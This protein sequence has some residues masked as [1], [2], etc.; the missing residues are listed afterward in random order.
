MVLSKDRIMALPGW[1]GF[2]A[3]ATSIV[4]DVNGC[5]ACAARLRV[6]SVGHVA[7]TV[8]SGPRGFG[9]SGERQRSALRAKAGSF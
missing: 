9:H 7:N 4:R 5:A 3:S 2:A 1:L 8:I 6:P